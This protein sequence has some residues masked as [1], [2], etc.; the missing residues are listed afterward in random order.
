[1]P[2]YIY[3][4][5]Y[6]V[7]L[8][9]RDDGKGTFSCL[10]SGDN[11]N[12]SVIDGGTVTINSGMVH[13]VFTDIPVMECKRMAN[14]WVCGAAEVVPLDQQTLAA[15]LAFITNRPTM[16]RKVSRPLWVT[17]R[18]VACKIPNE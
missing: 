11:S 7:N 10:Q 18:K 8:E 16:Q 12:P 15:V 6:T 2:D 1:M 17:S 4:Y 9:M 3:R 13:Y 14:A 5:L